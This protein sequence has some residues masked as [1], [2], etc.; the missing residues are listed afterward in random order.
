M[1]DQAGRVVVVTGGTSGV[2][3]AFARALAARGATVVLMARSE[4]GGEE[5]CAAIRREVPGAALQAVAGDLSD[6]AAARSA[7]ERIRAAHPQ[8][9][10]LATMAGVFAPGGRRTGDGVEIHLATNVVSAWSTMCVLRDSLLRGAPARVVLLSG[11]LHR[12][13]VFDADDIGLEHGV[14]ALDAA[15][16]TMLYKVAM[17]A[18][19]GRRTPAD[20]VAFNAVCP[21]FT[22]TGLLRNLPWHLRAAGAVASLF[23]QS[24][25]RGARTA[26]HVATAP[27]L[28][29]V[30]GR[31]FRH[32]RECAPSA[33]A[34]DPSVAEAILAY[35]SGLTGLHWP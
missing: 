3:H 33:H 13:A 16:R 30:T 7:A 31:Y 29:G 23:A 32:L 20:R 34:V 25:T 12:N 28:A 11:N 21:G 18:G 8:V 5:A 26:V 1:G 10:V 27:E 19:L 9:H 22:R 17:A 2:G 4:A 24:P 35:L 15:K 14:P 6:M